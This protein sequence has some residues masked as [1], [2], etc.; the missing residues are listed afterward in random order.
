MLEQ[1]TKAFKVLL[2]YFLRK[3]YTKVTVNRWSQIAVEY[4]VFLEKHNKSIDDIGD[5]LNS[6]GRVVKK[7]EFGAKD[8]IDTKT[9]YSASYLN[10]LHHVLKRFYKAWEKHFPIENDDFP[11][12]SGEPK[13][14]FLNE[15]QLLKTADA[16]KEM[17]LEAVKKNPDDITG[18]RDYAMVLIS[19]D[20][21]ARRI[22]ISELNI[23]NYDYETSILFVLRAKGGRDTFRPLSKMTRDV[24]VFYLRKRK[25]LD[26]KDKAMFLMKDNERRIT[27]SSMTDRLRAIAERAGVYQNGIGFHAPRRGKSLRLKQSKKFSEE[28]INEVFGWK[29]G[30]KMSH[31]YGQLDQT[32][33]Q[34]KAADVDTILKKRKE[35]KTT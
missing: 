14:P 6:E 35:D 21:G 27:V 5:L 9:K 31:I 17:W 10:Y 3:K 7:E 20:T 16:A 4:L 19:I 24:L 2:K 13:R 32:E 15:E 12:L 28:E 18:L 1:D 22:Q 11:K 34:R 23:D 33:L 26:T 30:S 8:F 29:K 25:A